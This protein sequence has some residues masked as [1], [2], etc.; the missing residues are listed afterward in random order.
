[1]RMPAFSR[2]TRMVDA[3]LNRRCSSAAGVAI[4][5][6]PPYSSGS[7]GAVIARSDPP[8]YRFSELEVHAAA[9]EVGGEVDVR[10]RAGAGGAAVEAAEV[11]V[12]IFR[13][14]G[15]VPA[16]RDFEAAARGPAGVGRARRAEARDVGLDVAGRETA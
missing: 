1:M 4:A 12:E 11:D 9:H 15:P 6:P 3:M 13:L 8:T 10:R 2:P 7:R 16:E 14:G 5:A